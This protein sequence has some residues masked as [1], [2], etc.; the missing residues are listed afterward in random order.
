MQ[1]INTINKINKKKA[2]TPFI[3]LNISLIT[4]QAKAI[5]AHSSND[6]CEKSVIYAKKSLACKYLAEVLELLEGYKVD[7][8]Q[9]KM[10]Y[11][12]RGS[13]LETY[14]KEIASLIDS[15]GLDEDIPKE[16]LEDAEDLE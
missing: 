6:A 4:S 15:L 10:K 2:T 1:T 14:T 16:D 9:E 12:L 13:Q 5:V 8:A 3:P 7:L 11:R